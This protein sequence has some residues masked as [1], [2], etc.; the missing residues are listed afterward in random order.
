MDALAALVPAEV[1]AVH[2]VIMQLAVKT[3]EVKGKPQVV[4]D[5]SASLQ[6]L[7]L[8]FTLLAGGLFLA[9]R[10]FPANHVKAPKP[11]PSDIVRF[12][13]PVLAFIAWSMLQPA[14]M[15]DTLSWWNPDLAIRVGIALVA[16]LVLGGAAW[17]LGIRA[18]AR[19][20]AS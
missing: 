17:I 12:L 4:V 11:L 14:S 1:L 5:R 2:A 8:V 15:F 10:F 3:T 20:P 6:V 13:V 16:A 9:A 19:E 18:D 7:Y